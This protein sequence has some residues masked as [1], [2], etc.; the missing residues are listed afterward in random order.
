VHAH[1][2]DALT[3]SCAV[4][5]THWDGGAGGGELAGPKPQMFFAPTQVQKRHADW[6]P[7]EFQAKVG[8]AWKHFLKTAASSTKVVTAS[9]LHEAA[10]VL[11]GLVAG[12]GRA[13]EGNVIRLR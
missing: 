5:A 12:D 10:K 9:G 3:Y 8:E 7:A 2:N 11:A 13:D 1:F 6:G 4:G